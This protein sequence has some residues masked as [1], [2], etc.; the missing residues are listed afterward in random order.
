MRNVQWTEA[1][2]F[3]I[4]GIQSSVKEDLGCSSSELASARGNGIYL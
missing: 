3:I 1:L 4:P 2:L